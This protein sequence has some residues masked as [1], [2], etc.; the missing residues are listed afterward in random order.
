MIEIAGL[1]K[2]FEVENPKK[3]SEQEKKDPRL[4]GRY[5]Q[6]V[7]DVSFT[8]QSGEVLG[9]LGPNGAG[10]TTTLRMLSTALRPDSGS[11]LIDGQDILDV[12]EESK[13]KLDLLVKK[14][15]DAKIKIT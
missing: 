9:L 13:Y 14:K 1:A 3:L 12:D 6:S 2:R 7:R 10:K 15:I 4:K 5:F 8:C 11:V